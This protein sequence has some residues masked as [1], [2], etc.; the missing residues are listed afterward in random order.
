MGAAVIVLIAFA[1]MIPLTAIVLDSPVVRA[2]VERMQGGKVEDGADLK[3]LS[4]KVDTLET[5][6]ETMGR[7]L[8]QIQEEHQYMQRLL[9]DPAHRSP[10]PKSLPKSGS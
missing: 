2:W 10:P 4:K 3:E 8:A 1:L 7:Q 9:E 6:L 5:E